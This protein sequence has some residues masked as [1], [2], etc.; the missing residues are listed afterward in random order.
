MI[1]G[2]LR[3]QQDYYPRVRIDRI[4]FIGPVAKRAPRI[5]GFHRHN[6]VVIDRANLPQAV[7]IRVI[8]DHSA[9]GQNV[10]GA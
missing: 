2:T 6:L 10:T 5:Y 1:A 9:I 8:R 3:R 7:F 4:N